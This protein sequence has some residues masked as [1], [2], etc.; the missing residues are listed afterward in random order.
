M[1]SSKW[2]TLLAIRAW[3][4]VFAVVSA[5]LLAGGYG[6]YRMEA[7]RI[8]QEEYQNLAAIA[9]MKSE[10]ILRWR[11]ERLADAA[12]VS[13]GPVLRRDVA[14]MIRHADTPGLRDDLLKILTVSQE[15]GLYS[16]VSIFTPDGAMLLATQN[17]PE[18]AEPVTQRAI[19][20]AQA[21]T[22]PILSGFFRAP[23]GRIYIA[24]VA[25]VRDDGGRPLAVVVLRSDA[26]A[27]LYRLIQSWPTP[28]RSAETL[29]VQQEGKQIVFLN[30]LRYRAATALSLRIPLTDTEHP[31]VQAAIGRRGAFDGKDYRHVKVLA[32][33]RPIEGTSWFMVTK[34]DAD[35]I[36]SEARYRAYSIS[37][38]VTTSILLAA[39]LVAYA[40]RRRQA[41]V[42]QALFESERQR[43]MSQE[44][45]RTTLYSIGDGIIT[46]DTESRVREMNRVA[47]TMTGWTEEQ[48][49]GKPLEDVFKIINQDT[50]A[51]VLNPVGTVLRDGVVVGLANHTLLISR[52][53]TE[54]AIA[55]S[56]A[57]ICDKGGKISGVVLVFSDVTEKYRAA[58]ALQAS[59][60]RFRSLL[61]NVSS[62][63]VRS[64]GLDGVVHYWNQASEN[65]YGYTE[66]EAIGSNT[67]DLI[68]PPEMRQEA[69]R[70][71][72][73]L[74]TACDPIP[75]REFSHMRKD[76]SRVIIISSLA[77]VRAPD[78]PCEF[79]CFD[80]DITERKRL[81][82]QLL[83]TQ[84][85]ESIGTL[86]S[87]VAHDLNNILAPIILS[88]DLLRNESDPAVRESLVET[89]ET[90]AQRG[91]NVVHQVITFARGAKGEKTTLQLRHLVNEMEKIIRETFPKNI[92]IANHAA[93]D[94]WP[95]KGNPT[96]IHQVLLN[97]CIN[98]RDAMPGGGT[99]KISA[100]NQEIDANFAAMTPEA[101]PGC[102]AVL[103][104]ADTGTGIPREII[105]KIFDPFF[106]TKE[107]GKGI[108]LGLSTVIG[109]VRSHEG[110][111]T[112]ESEP[113]QGTSF[114]VFLPADTRELADA[115]R[116]TAP[117][118]QGAD[119]TIL[120]VDDDLPVCQ[121]ITSVLELNG[122]KVLTAPDGPRALSLYRSRA[123][124]I[125]LV[126]TDISMP[127]M[128]G[129]ELIRE[130]QVINPQL[131]AIASSGQAAEESKAQLRACGVKMILHKPYDVGKLLAAVGAMLNR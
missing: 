50:R 105:G 117:R 83:R 76:G 66:A 103:E 93:S 12:R 79:F 99:L 67:L 15:R 40:Y 92:A 63:A 42:Y 120:V 121:S 17:A 88:A 3:A 31:A 113:G 89:I 21:R 97:L 116:Q 35:E 56:A 86:A 60:A 48:A 7:Q 10:Q 75:L 115:P 8:H 38:V 111:V 122:Y 71:L 130:L 64:F 30:E 114:K 101:K 58:A 126:L 96:Q 46:T 2:R 53:G 55:D 127:T 34:M 51:K 33:L 59:E 95:V 47:E 52:D 110:F 81:E 84:R 28:S 11:K 87:G 16:N 70:V 41:G 109:I 22:E 24:A 74:A 124:E 85:M 98:A 9:K 131:K 104:I 23:D 102:Y 80:I 72:E 57:P 6:Y 39:A 77:I 107:V 4:T 13:K 45:F 43:R 20:D 119:E 27:Y 54:R 100:D 90:C 91:A 5:V 123:E 118:R 18:T 106:T 36:M 112:V 1:T 65:L 44:Q 25:T 125:R 61:Q 62:V 82:V 69:E 14:E 94:L 37:F 108:G 73:Q 32:D 78:R 19:A 29:L 68:V 26:A 49:R 128:D 129:V